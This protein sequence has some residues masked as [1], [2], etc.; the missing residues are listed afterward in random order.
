M[1]YAIIQ[2]EKPY[3]DIVIKA[4]LPEN[5]YRLALDVIELGERNAMEWQ[6]TLYEKQSG[7]FKVCEGVYI[8]GD[9]TNL[10]AYNK[11]GVAIWLTE[12]TAK[13]RIT[14]KFEIKYLTQQAMS[15]NY[16]LGY[17]LYKS[18]Q[19]QLLEQ[20]EELEEHGDKIEW[21][22]GVI[23]ERYYNKNGSDEYGR[24][25]RSKDDVKPPYNFF[26]HF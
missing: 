18:V 2:R 24:Y 22:I 12:K 6:H 21:L 16:L 1:P 14:P 20:L 10:S 23:N 17:N 3:P 19:K 9:G 11:R 4:E 8:K 25:I 26:E 5:A 7:S 15:T 13:E